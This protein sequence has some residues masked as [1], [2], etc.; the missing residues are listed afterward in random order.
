MTDFDRLGSGCLWLRVLG[1]NANRMT[2]RTAFLELA[3]GRGRYAALLLFACAVQV[4]PLA[5]D[6]RLLPALSGGLECGVVALRSKLRSSKAC[7]TRWT[8]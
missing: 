8:L 1:S 7:R 4:L 2:V 5:V 6:M 3:G